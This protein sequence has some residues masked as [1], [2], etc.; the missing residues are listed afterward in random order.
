MSGSFNHIVNEVGQFTMN[1]LEDMGECQEALKECF[2]LIMVL[3][4]RDWGKVDSAMKELNPIASISYKELTTVE[5]RLSRL[6][7]RVF[8]DEY[9]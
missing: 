2:D 5:D 4:G 3:S 8:C 6:E 9:D 7:Q 1:S